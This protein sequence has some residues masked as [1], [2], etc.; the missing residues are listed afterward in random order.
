MEWLV[1]GNNGTQAAITAGYSKKIAGVT[2]TKVLQDPRA[3]KFLKQL[4]TERAKRYGEQLDEVLVQLWFVCTRDVRE[5]VDEKTGLIKKLSD[6][7][8]RERSA[9]EGIEVV[10][11]FDKFGQKTVKTKLKLVPKNPA[12]DMAMKHRGLYAAEKHQVGPIPGFDL[13]QLHGMPEGALEQDEIEDPPDKSI[14]V[15]DKE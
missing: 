1:N 6:M 13:S 8:L 2:A 11:S 3:Q 12:M 7:P 15:V 5:Y 14:I 9:I 10:E 4:M